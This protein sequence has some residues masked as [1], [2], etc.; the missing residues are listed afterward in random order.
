MYKSWRD[1]CI[2]LRESPQC[3]FIPLGSTVADGGN[4]GNGGD[5]TGVVGRLPGLIPFVGVDTGGGDNN[6]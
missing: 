2:T 3:P 1:K 6:D 5:E 4:G